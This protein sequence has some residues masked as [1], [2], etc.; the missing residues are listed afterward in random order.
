MKA[1]LLAFVLFAS[2]T[3]SAVRA[4]PVL[5]I[6]IDGL[7]PGDVL[8]AE[9]RGLK[10][11]NL[12]RF[13][14]EGAYATGVSGVL[15]TLTY[16]SHTTLITGVSPARH[17]VVNNFTFDPTLI[18]QGG[19]YWYASDITAQTLWQAAAAGKHSV[20]NVH[21]PVSVG[22]SGI[23]WNLPQIWRTGHD[24]D[25]KLVNA[26]ATPGLIASLEKA[27]GEGYAP[28][29]AEDIASDEKRGRFA[30]KLIE[31]RK[32][33]FATVY[34]AALDHQQHVDGPDTPSAHAVLER[35]DAIVGKLVAAERSAHPDAVIAVA[36]DHGFAAVNHEFN[37]YRAFI[38]ARLIRL[39]ADGKIKEWDAVPWSS[40]GSIAIV[41][42]RPTDAALTGK[43]AGLLSQLQADPANGI[44]AV[45]DK[46]AI[47]KAGGNPRASFYLDLTTGTTFSGYT[48]ADAP[49]NS[50]PHYKGMHGYFPGNPLMRSTFMVMGHGVPRGKSLG[51]IDM[52]AIAPTLAR[53]LKVRLEGA[54]VPALKF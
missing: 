2:L 6:S 50:T 17:G 25:A 52:R 8:E 39:T 18:N 45:I 16:P 15:P 22:A 27:T 43:V 46:A 13:L 31:T 12:R 44:A 48:G 35:I 24:D 54:E 4:E 37:L 36:S 40:G 32:P 34:L 10:V 9:Q 11:P 42:A 1:A 23:T 51:E 19:W 21:W 14:T 7:R 53:I 47:D 49:L 38:D 33:G 5:L 28:G 29:I 41:L 3:A 26:L 30:V 20:A